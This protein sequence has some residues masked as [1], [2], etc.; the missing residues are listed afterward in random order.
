[1]SIDPQARG[2]ARSRF[3]TVLTALAALA[4]TTV[5]PGLAGTA[6][7]A[8]GRVFEMTTPVP[9]RGYFLPGES[10]SFAITCLEGERYERVWL[11]EIG[12]GGWAG[13]DGWGQ[14]IDPY[15]APGTY[16]WVLE[17]TDADG[18]VVDSAVI[19]AEIGSALS[20]AATVGT[21]PGECADTDEI[22]VEAGTEVHWCYRLI[23]H[24]DLEYDIFDDW[25]WDEVDHAVSDTLNGAIGSATLAQIPLLPVEG[26][27]TLDL[28]IASSSIATET[29]DNTGTWS[30]V[31]GEFDEY[32]IDEDDDRDGWERFPIDALTATA[33]VVV[34]DAGEDPDAGT[35]GPGTTTPDAKAA[36][37]VTSTPTYTG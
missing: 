10:I 15:A 17:C 24:P 12:S 34:L 20:L 11:D 30:V 33:R 13:S 29:V 1:M 23:P 19:T 2:R 7:A 3:I 21:T 8:D 27:T 6:Q 28:G 36:T 31:F 25:I 35:P 14:G 4:A 22:T 16:E 9:E 5:A 18:T 37:P 26:V 32:D